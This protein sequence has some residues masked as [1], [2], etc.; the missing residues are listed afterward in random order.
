MLCQLVDQ[1]SRH[2]KR[3]FIGKRNG[4]LGTDGVDRR[5]QSGIAHHCRQHHIHRSGL[6]D[7]ADRVDSGIYFDRKVAQRFLQLGV[8]FFVGYHHHFRLELACLCNQQF[9]PVVGRQGIGF[10]EVGVFFDHLQ[11]LRPDRARRA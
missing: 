5:L 10:V 1:L 7:L 8:L 3:L 11:R 4:F 9:Y 6:H 2:H